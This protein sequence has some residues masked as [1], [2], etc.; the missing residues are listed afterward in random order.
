MVQIGKLGMSAPPPIKRSA[1]IE[2]LLSKLE[3]IFKFIRN[4]VV[5]SFVSGSKVNFLRWSILHN[6]HSNQMVIFVSTWREVSI[7]VMIEGVQHWF[8]FLKVGQKVSILCIICCQA[9]IWNARVQHFGQRLVLKLRYIITWLTG[10]PNV[11][12]GE[13][14]LVVVLAQLLVRSEKAIFNYYQENLKKT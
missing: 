13:I 8:W 10:S 6:W 2:I 7:L 14:K 11:E 9:F 4:L 3:V 1:C 5:G 12:G